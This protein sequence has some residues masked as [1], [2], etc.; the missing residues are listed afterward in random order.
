MHILKKSILVST[1]S[2][3]SLYSM[4]LKHAP[5][6]KPLFWHKHSDVALTKPLFMHIAVQ[7]SSK[8]NLRYFLQKSNYSNLND[9]FCQLSTRPGDFINF[10][11]PRAFYHLLSYIPWERYKTNNNTRAHTYP[12]RLNGISTELLI[13]KNTSKCIIPHHS[14]VLVTS[15]FHTDK[16][17]RQRHED[18]CKEFA[19]LTKNI[20]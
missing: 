9:G 16:Q 18:V 14:L 13:M 11:N 4:Y 19:L 3:I 10:N 7:V 17:H 6:L 2:I 20:E 8:L 1:L 15:H 12:I 5:D